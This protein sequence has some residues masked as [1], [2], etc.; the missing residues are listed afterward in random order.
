[1]H[2]LRVLLKERRKE[3]NMKT[4]STVILGA[5][6][7]VITAS[8]GNRAEAADVYPAKPIFFIVPNEAGASADILARPLMQ[9][10]SAMLGQPVI[11]VN[12]PGGGSSIGYR[13]LYGSKPDGYTIGQASGTIVTNKLQGLLPYDYHDFTMLGVYLNWVPAVIA[14]TKT[15]HPFN[16]FGEVVTYAKANPGGI[17]VATGSV[18]QLWWV[19]SVALDESSGLNFNLIPQS[20]SSGATAQQVAG[21]HTD[22]GIIDVAST[23]SHIQAGLVRVLAVFGAQRLPGEFSNVPTVKEFGYDVVI[24]STH[25]VMGPPK[26]PK[27]ITDKLVKTIEGAA[28]DPEYLKF[29]SQY[30]AAPFYL[31]PDQAINWFD[32]QRKTMRDIMGKAGILKDK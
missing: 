22:L 15:K 19:A 11:V 27:D 6:L 13:E 1:M 17:S 23:K 21:G 30:Y 8:G 26:M 2:K 29:I 31:P 20:A 14:S 18:G 32:G 28:K 3:E 10:V 16:T 7:V 4:L 12:K 9:K 25:I 5:L 24:T